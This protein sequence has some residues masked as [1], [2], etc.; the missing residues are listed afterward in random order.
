MDAHRV[1]RSSLRAA[2][3]VPSRFGL[4]AGQ[5]HILFDSSHGDHHARPWDGRHINGAFASV[6]F[7]LALAFASYLAPLSTLPVFVA[8]ILFAYVVEEWIHYS[9]HFHRLPGRYFAYIRLHHHYHHSGRGQDAAF[10]LSSGVWDV[11]L[12]TRIPEHDR[13]ALY[14]RARRDRGSVALTRT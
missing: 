9:V 6:P 14:L 5:L 4:A 7:A 8:T 1:S 12:R 13:R 11:P 10:G 2:R 3:R